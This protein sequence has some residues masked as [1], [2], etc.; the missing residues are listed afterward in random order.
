MNERDPRLIGLKSAA[1]A[2][3]FAL[4]GGSSSVALL[5]HF[6]DVHVGFLLIFSL[7]FAAVCVL[8]FMRTGAGVMAGLLMSLV[9]WPV[10]FMAANA[11]GIERIDDRLP[12][13]V[14]GLVG[15]LG[16]A[17]CASIGNRSFLSA[18]Y[19]AICAVIGS[20]A[21]LAFASWLKLYY[22]TD[23]NRGPM[24]NPPVPMVAFAIWQTSVGTY[25]YAIHLTASR[26]AKLD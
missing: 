26:R 21:G 6:P 19:L 25:L 22:A 11:V 3:V 24:A 20:T 12:G 14:G 18:K 4:C 15:A 10:S 17:L 8:L 5:P 7:P 1:A 13:C 2:M 16:L 9:V 23:I